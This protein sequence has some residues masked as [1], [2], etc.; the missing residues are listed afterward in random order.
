MEN[1]SPYWPKVS[2]YSRHPCDVRGKSLLICHNESLGCVAFQGENKRQWRSFN[3]RQVKR[4]IQGFCRVFYDLDTAALGFDGR[5]A[6]AGDG[7]PESGSGVPI[8]RRAAVQAC[9]A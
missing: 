3:V 8:A 9:F 4:G 6:F 2:G 1:L 7:G 5:A